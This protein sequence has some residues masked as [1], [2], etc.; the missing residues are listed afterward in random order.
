M[1]VIPVNVARVSMQMQ[2]SLLLGDLENTQQSM[3][4]VEQQLSSGQ[5]LSLPSDDPAAA[6]GIVS[7]KQQ[8]SDSTNYSSN[9]NF[10]TGILGQA[11][12]S[13]GSLQSLLNQAQSI[14]SS[15]VNTTTSS[16][17][18]TADAQVINSII[19]QAMDIG[20]QQY[21]GQSVFGGQ[22]GSSNAFA[23]VG[24]GYLYQGTSSPQ[25]I[26][27]PTG[28]SLDVTLSGDQVFGA[29]SSQVVGYQ[30]LT[31]ALTGGTQLSDLS[32][33][34]LDGVKP[35]TVNLT[36]GGTTTSVDLSSAASVNDVVN[37]LNAA[38]TAAGSDATIS[39]SG[40]SLKITGD[41]A[42]TVSISDT[43]NGSTAAQLGIAVSVPANTN[44]TGAALGPKITATTPLSA[45][46]N[47]T[48]IDPSGIVITNGS[49]TA[50]ITLSG[51]P[52]LNTVQD[53]LNAINHS[54]TNVQATINNAGTGINLLNPLSGTS[55]TVGENGGNTAQE[56]GIRSL[57]PQ[58]ELSAFNNGAGVTPIAGTLPGPTGDITV[59][60]TDGTQFSVQ[61]NG[62]STPSGLIAAINSATG[63]TG[64][65]AVMNASG[66]GIT[67]NDTSGGAGNLSV[68][69]GSNYQ[70][71]GS[72]LGIFQTGAGGTLTGTGITFSTDDFR[73]TRQDGT[74][75]DVSVNGAAT[76]QDVLNDINNAGGNTSPANKVTAS[77]NTT[78]NGISL[79]DASTGSGKLAVT[80]LNASSAAGQLGIAQTA[81]S[82]MPGQIPGTDNNPLQ[83]EGL[84]SS[85]AQ[86]RDAHLNND[87]SGI[88]AAA[89]NLTNAAAQITEAQGIVGAREQDVSSRQS[90]ATN[91]QTQLKQALSLLN[92]TDFATAATQLQQLQTAYQAALQV[93][94]ITNN[95]SL[96]D[97]LQ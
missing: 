13:L 49:N 33:A 63:N 30:N 34:T 55:M 51:P 47:G 66:N 5:A 52:A 37:D 86:L 7:L 44:V 60:E 8:I 91:Q 95:M 23:S 50:T 2:G 69:A 58:T 28:G 12:S 68:A 78:G 3:L 40:G 4:T 1:S 92:D 83:P 72:D 70:G 89:G 10:A 81:T 6:L 93:G 67:L 77:L 38:I 26:L 65:T 62:V 21:E 17:Q 43:Q 20:N 79:S 42:Q 76:V 74:W 59:T 85:L 35:G 96:L 80:P 64:V 90:D 94:Q 82:S 27:T 71:N 46:D 19:N 45:L 41:T 11:D 61:M 32:G 97:F 25:T 9:L 87:T 22:N 16:S 14:A 57:N 56:L 88:T 75:F 31:P 36:V 18:R 73:I 24:G 53:L 39:T 15:D 29:I 54:G 48:G 84:F